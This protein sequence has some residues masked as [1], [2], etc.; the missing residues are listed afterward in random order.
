MNVE[1]AFGSAIDV[2]STQACGYG[3]GAVTPNATLFKR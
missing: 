3:K 2:L 1:H